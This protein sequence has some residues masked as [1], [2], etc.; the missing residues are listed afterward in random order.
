VPAGEF[1]E[2]VDSTGSLRLPSRAAS[3]QDAVGGPVADCTMNVA[4][5]ES[6]LPSSGFTV[7]NGPRTAGQSLSFI[8]LAVASPSAIRTATPVGKPNARS[9]IDAPG[10]TAHF[11]MERE[12]IPIIRNPRREPNGFHRMYP[13]LESN[14]RFDTGIAGVQAWEPG[15]HA[16]ER[17][18]VS[19]SIPR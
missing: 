5:P 18:G 15:F 19:V 8:D 13:G 17:V 7:V 10:E 2:R 12:S 9:G 1:P 16:P 4:M 11:Q 14:R 3:A 6:L